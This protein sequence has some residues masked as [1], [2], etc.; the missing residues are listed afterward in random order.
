MS[1]HDERQKRRL[2]IAVQ[3]RNFEIELF[4]KRSV[5]FWG[6]ISA[7][8]VGYA[9]LRIANPE[10]GLMIACFGMVCSGAWTLL[11]RGSKY[12]QESWE[13]KVNE[14]EI[15]IGGKLFTRQELTQNKGRWLRGRKY[16]V[17][18][19]AIALSDYVFLLWFSL[20]IVEVVRSYCPSAKMILRV[21]GPGIFALFS[22]IYLLLLLIFGRKS[23]PLAQTE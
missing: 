14:A 18:K 12:W 1:E 3:V 19:L 21:Y 11:N 15:D 7:A 10:L 23:K 6:F 13:T 9:A 17:S 16:S 20:V 8:F 4:W 2:D 22:F 5:F